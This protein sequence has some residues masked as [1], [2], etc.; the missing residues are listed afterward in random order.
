[1]RIQ[2]WSYNYDPEPQG[3]A[4]LS[5]MLA[6]ELAARGHN[7][8][9]ASAHPHYPEPNWGMRLRPYRENRD[10]IPIL[11]LPL[12]IGRDKG[13][14]RGRKDL[15]FTLVQALVAPLLPA[16]DAVIAVTP[17]FPALAPAMAFARARHVP[18][19][20]WL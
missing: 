14:A 15:S 7:V 13:R 20:M 3:V 12:W 6:V 4:P 8:L 5:R 2:L 19:I 11:R 17:S 18:W 1:M 9:V 10:G 16:T